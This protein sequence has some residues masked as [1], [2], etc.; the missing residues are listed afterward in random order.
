MPTMPNHRLNVLAEPA[1]LSVPNTFN[2]RTAIRAAFLVV[3]IGMSFALPRSDSASASGPPTINIIDAVSR[4]I[5]DFILGMTKPDATNT[6]VPGSAPLTQYIGPATLTAPNINYD[7][8]I[9]SN[10]MKLRASATGSTF[11]N[12]LFQGP[13]VAPLGQ[14]ALLSS[15]PGIDGIEI[16]RCTFRPRVPGYYVN[17][18]YGWG[19][20]TI[21]RC[22]ISRVVDGIDPFGGSYFV[23]GNYIHDFAH[24]SPSPTNGDNQTHND[25][26]QIQGGSG[27]VVVGNNFQAF[28]DMAVS[29]D[30][31]GLL[32]P[33]N[34]VNSCMMIKPDVSDISSLTVTDNWLDGGMYSINIANRSASPVRTIG[35]LGRIQRNRFG[36]KQ[37]IQGPGGNSTFTIDLP[38]TSVCDTGDGT[39][40]Q[41]LYADSG[42][43]V[44]VR[45]T[46]V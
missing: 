28:A 31:L 23:F 20:V 5:D 1:R 37:S 18:I 3:P 32:G 46:N 15:E 30:T 45:R 4:G 34:Q 11:T 12:C 39:P 33:Q 41:N 19:G 16:T 22:D 26:M 7:G 8:L 10:F 14:S 36:R 35:N 29:T 21:S 38:K 42:A 2:R 13:T 17:G 6:G 40:N 9:F 44:T 27:T 25:A 24:Y 43:A